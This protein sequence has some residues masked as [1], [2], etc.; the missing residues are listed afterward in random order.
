[1][2]CLAQQKVE[3]IQAKIDFAIETSIES[4]NL[5]AINSLEDSLNCSKANPYTSYW[6]AY[7]KLQKSLYY[8]GQHSDSAQVTLTEGIKILSDKENCTTED[9]ALLA[10]LQIMSIRYL[11]GL[12]AG[13]MS[14]KA[15][16]NARKAI[17]ADEQNLRGWF[18]SAMLD[19]Y[20]PKQFGGKKRCEELWMKALE[21]PEQRM[22]NPYLPSWGKEDAYVMLTTYYKELGNNKK[23]LPLIE[24]ALKEY[25]QNETFK[26]YA[27]NTK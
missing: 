24:K 18:V 23:L 1:M 11:S 12:E 3:G 6:Q 4:H 26:K 14:Q 20:T 17:Q 15:A 25:P 21:L 22:P 10:Y 9:F 2:A 19:Y 8:M 13:V 27:Q 7:I 5:R 16:N